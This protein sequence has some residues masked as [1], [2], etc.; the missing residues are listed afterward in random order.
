MD[1][2]RQRLEFLRRRRGFAALP[3]NR[4]WR[5][6]AA[7]RASPM[8]RKNPRRFR[9]VVGLLEDWAGLVGLCC[10]LAGYQPFESLFLKA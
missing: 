2:P 4:L 9:L 5:L 6:H 7:N 1:G 3:N 8:D 10:N